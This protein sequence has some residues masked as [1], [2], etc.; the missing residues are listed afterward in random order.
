MTEGGINKEEGARMSNSW[1]PLYKK[2]TG[3][4]K[5]KGLDGVFRR[6]LGTPGEDIIKAA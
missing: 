3:K 4:R 6:R 1:L 2:M 5:A